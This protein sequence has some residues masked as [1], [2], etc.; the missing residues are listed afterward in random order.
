MANEAGENSLPPDG[1]E[2]INKEEY[3]IVTQGDYLRVDNLC[4]A[5]LLH[6]YEHLLAG[7]LAPEEATSLANGADFFLRDFLVDF[8]GYNLFDEKPGIVKQFAGN[9]YIV[10]TAE[11]DI[12]QLSRHLQG[13]R[14]F[15]GWLCGQGLI[16]G[17]YL[18][19]LE[20]ECGIL[21]FYEAR[22]EAFWRIEGDGF[23]EWER[24][25]TLKDLPAATGRA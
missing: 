9:W 5:L 13:I 16:S 6:F 7:G 4:K 18:T 11:P 25:C 22:I 3:S 24:E 15:Y 23:H 19:I 21:S 12:Q 10:N 14:A 17:G 2:R 8:K 20:K 1:E